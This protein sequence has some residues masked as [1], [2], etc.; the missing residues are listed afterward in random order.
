MDKQEN[1]A[2]K[3]AKFKGVIFDLDGTL[4]D[5]G[6]DWKL[7]KKELSLFCFQEKGIKIEFTP[8]NKKLFEVKEKTGEF[9]YLKI[10][11]IVAKFEIK[12][13]NYKLNQEL[14]DYINYSV[15]SQKIA[16]FSMNTKKCIDNFIKKH[17]KKIPDVV[18]SKESCIKPKP[19]RENLEEIMRRWHMNKTEIIYIGNSEADRLSGEMAGLKTYIIPFFN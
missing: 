18:I 12:E 14:L 11:D 2:T 16:I 8:L 10:L 13:K 6:I 19:S 3:L 1:I 4:V 15:N 9:F 17:L 5:L 7:M